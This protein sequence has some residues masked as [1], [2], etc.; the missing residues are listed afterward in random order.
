MQREVGGDD[1][2]GNG[3]SDADALP[4]LEHKL[5]ESIQVRPDECGAGVVAIPRSV[6]D[7]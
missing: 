1:I 4:Q 2:G 7:A 6:G 5:A 3:R